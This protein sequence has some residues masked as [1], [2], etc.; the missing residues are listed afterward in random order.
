MIQVKA[1]DGSIVQFPDGMPE[2]EMLAVMQKEFG[3]PTPDAPPPADMGLAVAREGLTG[4][5]GA[6]AFVPQIEAFLKSISGQGTYAENLPKVQQEQKQFQEQ[7]PGVSTAAQIAGGVATTLPLAATSLGASALG[8]TGKTL[9]GMVGKG[10]L[11]GTA[12]G[13]IDALARG[14]D[15]TTGAAVGGAL[16]GAIPIAGAGIGKVVGAL[17]KTPATAPTVEAL[18]DAARAG[19]EAPAVKAV[20]LNPKAISQLADDIEGILIKS[21]HRDYLSPGTFKAIQ[22]LKSPPTGVSTLDDIEGVRQVLGK[23]AMS[24]TERAAANKA[25]KKLDTFEVGLKESDIIAGDVAE[26]RKIITDARANWG[27]AKRGETIGKAEHLAE[28]NAR[29]SG[30]GTNIDNTTRQQ[31]KGILR[32]ENKQRGFSAEE[33]SQMEKTT[34]GSPATNVLR[35]I[36]KLGPAGGL[37]TMIHVGGALSTAGATIPLS[38]GSYLSRKLADKLT[39]TQLSRLDEMVRNRSPLGKIMTESMKI[40]PSGELSSNMRKYVTAM[41]RG[42]QPVLTDR[43]SAPGR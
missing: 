29:T 2:T 38:I 37:S 24:H 19:Y 33:L 12:I 15:P 25:M 9:A 13:G 21:G 42:P 18:K 23:A 43:L 27:A 6:G 7:S 4:I 14:D 17:S 1:P 8:F 41:L 30:S 3:G 28:L 31:L 40:D 32:N 26:A 16:G 11:S 22:E 36:G 20:Q 5:P 34:F 39:A 10:A 35:G